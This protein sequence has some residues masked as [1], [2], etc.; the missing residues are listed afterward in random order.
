MPNV[1]SAKKRVKTNEKS[2]I[3]NRQA[4]SALRTAL[5]KAGAAITAGDLEAAKAA[6]PVA[7]SLIG[8]TA[9]K[10]MIHDNKAARQESRLTKKFNALAAT[11]APASA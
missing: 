6:L 3:R 8:K 2:N 4:K 5:K 1:K 10:G 9:K 11:K 7:L